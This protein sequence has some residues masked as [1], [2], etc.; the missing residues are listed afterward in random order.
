MIIII[1]HFLLSANDINIIHARK[2]IH[3]HKFAH[4]VPEQSSARFDERP[5]EREVDL[6]HEGRHAAHHT[7]ADVQNDVWFVLHDATIRKEM[8]GVLGHHSAL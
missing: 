3:P 2:N 8:V 1:I 5:V 4:T 6:P 7:V